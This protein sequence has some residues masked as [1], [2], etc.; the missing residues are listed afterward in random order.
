[1]YRVPSPRPVGDT[2]RSTRH[3]GAR[4]GMSRTGTHAVLENHHNHAGSSLMRSPFF[5]FL[6]LVSFL[7][8]LG[9]VAFA[10]RLTRGDGHLKHIRPGPWSFLLYSTST[11]HVLRTVRS[12]YIQYVQCKYGGSIRQ[13]PGLRGFQASR[14]CVSPSLLGSCGRI[15]F[16]TGSLVWT[17]QASSTNPTELGL[18]DRSSSHVSLTELHEMSTNVRGQIRMGD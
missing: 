16:R 9:F 6:L 10:L 3:R 4:V 2:N 7:A 1:M 14:L 11:P 5:F 12:T 8:F 18:S 15:N 13:F 17:S